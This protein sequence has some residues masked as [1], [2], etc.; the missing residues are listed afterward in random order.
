M[1]G[2]TKEGFENSVDH[3]YPWWDGNWLTYEDYK[4]RVELRADGCKE[5]D[6]PFLGP[7]LASNLV[8]KAFDSLG[9]ID[10]PKLRKKDGW[11]YLLT[12]L[13]NTRG[14]T[15]VD[16]LGDMFSEFFLRRDAYRKDSEEINDYETRYKNMVRRMEKAIKETNAEAQ[17]PQEVYGWFLLNIYMKMS[18]SDTANVRGRIKSYK[19]KD[20]MDV[21]R[22]MW[23]GGGLA[24]RDAELKA[25]KQSGG[26]TFNV[27]EV[28]NL[29]EP[30]ESSDD[31]HEE[32]EI[33]SWLDEAVAA[34]AAD[35]TDGEVLANFRDARKALDQ[36]RTSRGFYPVKMPGS[37]HYGK[38]KGKGKGKYDGGTQQGQRTCFRCG[39][40]GH[41]AKS[42]P[43]KPRT[44]GSIG[45]VGWCSGSGS[46]LPEPD[47]PYERT[48]LEEQVTDGSSQPPEMDGRLTAS[49]FVASLDNEDEEESVG[50]VFVNSRDQ[51]RG[52]AIIDSGASDNLVGAET[53][54]ELAQC[55][56]EM[57]FDPDH[58]IQVDREVHKNFVFG[59]N[60]MSAGLGL[61]HVNA[62][63]CGQQMP[64]QAHL[65]EGATPFLLSSKFLYDVDATINFRRGIAVFRQLSE[66]QIKLERTP[67]HHLLIPL[68]AFAG[69]T[70]V[71]ENLFVQKEEHDSMVASLSGEPKPSVT[72]HPD[73]DSTEFQGT[74]DD[75]S[76]TQGGTQVE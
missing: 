62:G 74:P 2:S 5:E 42:C 29:D 64:I 34:V 43:Q 47:V 18:P 60:E 21:L 15:K 27:D 16:L 59:N 71:V 48:Y 26:Q 30:N 25:K 69:N 54:Q 76:E 17:M 32:Q 40:P 11:S 28:Y 52:K 3:K 41:E 8:G 6:L 1:S 55:L 38:S 66:K 73:E 7:K 31:G 67:N 56:E 45:F 39:K 14:R 10:R 19:L 46:T 72:F 51:I 12:Y 37:G 61:S 53:L 22:A 20:V 75:S 36:A 35:P 57:E 49:I 33:L 65:V 63:I 70:P 24:S 50:E 9:D 44:T 13:E 68:M 58:E 23:S 4:T